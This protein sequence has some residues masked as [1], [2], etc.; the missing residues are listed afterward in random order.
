MI[1][2]CVFVNFDVYD[3]FFFLHCLLLFSL[4]FFVC[5]FV[6]LF[7]FISVAFYAVSLYRH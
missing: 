7:N 3:F 1:S 2:D 4:L 5:L 6:C